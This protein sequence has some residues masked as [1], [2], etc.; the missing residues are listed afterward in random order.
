MEP[1]APFSIGVASRPTW[2]TEPDFARSSE[3]EVRFTPEG[4]GLTR[5]D[6]EHR[7]F[8]RHGAGFETMRTAVKDPA[9]WSG[10][11]I[12]GSFQTRIE[13]ASFTREPACRP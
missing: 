11:G 1:A 3:V 10:S 9:G 4:D 5:V 13:Q 7:Y 6:L 8:E 12:L 2:Q